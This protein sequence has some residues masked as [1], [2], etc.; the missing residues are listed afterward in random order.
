MQS[1][2]DGEYFQWQR[3]IGE[4]EAAVG[5][6]KFSKFVK[7]EDR[8]IDFGCGGGYML[9]SFK[10]K[11]RIGIEI[12]ENARHFAQEAGAHVVRSANEI[13]D[14]WADVIISDNV[15]EHTT[16]PLYE[17][18]ILYRKL[19]PSGKIVFVIP[20]EIKISWKPGNRN[21]HLYTWSPMCAGNLFTAAGFNIEEIST[22]RRLWPPYYETIKKYLGLK[23]FYLICEIYTTILG[24]WH[25]IRVVATKPKENVGNRTIQR[26]PF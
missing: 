17:L 6:Y 16:C 3:K 15:L 10:C 2:Y 4:F 11:D 9:R 23:V 12:N 19:K 25:E 1:R 5:L 24:K 20:H 21:Q 14:D 26:A 8:V 7:P 18:R 22:I 13:E